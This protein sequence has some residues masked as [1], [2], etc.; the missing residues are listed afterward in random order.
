MAAGERERGAVERGERRSKGASERLKKASGRSDLLSRP[1]RHHECHD[2]ESIRRESRLGRKGGSVVC[3]AASGPGGRVEASWAGPG[4]LTCLWTHC[5][6]AQE[7]R[8]RGREV[9]RPRGQG[10]AGAKN[11]RTALAAQARLDPARS[12]SQSIALQAAHDPSGQASCAPANSSPAPA[13]RAGGKQARRSVGQGCARERLLSWKACPH[14]ADRAHRPW[15]T[16]ASRPLFPGADGS[17]G[18]GS[19]RGP[20]R[21]GERPEW[22]TSECEGPV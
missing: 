1:L 14:A 13:T 20:A 9:Q 5:A 8:R 18:M 21:A 3:G 17:A 19:A 7:A 22:L 6:A 10:Q 16:R 11:G 4:S 15:S 12:H 2:Q